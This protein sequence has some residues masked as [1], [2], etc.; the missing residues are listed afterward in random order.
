MGIDFKLYGEFVPG[1]DSWLSFSLM[2]T[3]MK[4]NGKHAPLPTDQR[5]AFNLFLAD[6]IPGTERLKG[7]LKLALADGL[8]FAAPHRDVT[9]NN[10]RAPAY[11]R[12]DLGF[13]YRIIDNE[14]T[15]IRPGADGKASATVYS[16][17]NNRILL[18]NLWLGIDCLNLFGINNVNS[19]YWVND[20][21]NNQYAVPNYLTGRQVNIKLTADF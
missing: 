16:R 6:Y 1:N 20:V 13:S 2:D 17:R 11:K 9:D 5:Y 18:R 3:D 21:A 10:F 19:Y 15:T 8:P 7:Y 14:R 12:C 4:L